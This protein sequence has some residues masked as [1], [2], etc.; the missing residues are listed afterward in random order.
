LR[1]A[2]GRRAEFDWLRLVA[3]GL[4]MLFHGAVGFSSWPWHVNDAHRS[5][6]LGDVLD[7]L[8]RW[9]VELVFVVS[10][11]ALMLALRRHTPAAILRERFQR[12]AIP[13]AF[14]MLV[15]VPPQVYFERLQHGQF[16]GSYV[17][18]LPHLADGIYPVGNLSWHHLWFMPYVLV[19][20]AVALP[21]FLW[22]RSPQ[23][24][25]WLDPLMQNIAD[26]HLYWLLV[27]P[28]GLAQMMLRLQASDNHTFIYD[29]HGWIEFG[30]LLMLGGVLAEWPAV[31]AA[32]QRERYASLVV[33]LVAYG[34]L[35]TEW[36]TITDNPSSLPLTGAIGWCNL[37]SLNVL[38]WVL[39]VTGFVTRWLSRS[40][41]TLTYATEA[42]LPVYILHQTLIVFAVYHLHNI[43]WPLG[44]KILMTVSFSLLGSLALY[45]LVIRRSRL[46]RLLFGVKQRAR[47]IGPEALMPNDSE[48]ALT[49]RSRGRSS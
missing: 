28:L 27:V 42:A 23:Q 9:R 32:I 8:W 4:M 22:M 43:N 37:S 36:P 45:E 15:I 13:L 40:S 17:D 7:F 29:G 35:K 16:H 2:A 21:L 26:K 44:A 31:L 39:A 14:G 46:L 41:P 25:E 33:G 47:E 1:Y 6:I 34:A 19:L 48:S 38:A 49:N 30:I 12:L 10:G 20:T 3:L 11:A 18:F 24:R 5:V